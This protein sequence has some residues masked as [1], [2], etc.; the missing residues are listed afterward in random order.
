MSIPKLLAI[1]GVI[2]VFSLCLAVAGELRESDDLSE[3]LERDGLVKATQDQIRAMHDQMRRIRDE[4]RATTAVAA[5]V[6]SIVAWHKNAVEQ[7]IGGDE[8]ERSKGGG[9]VLEHSKS[10]AAR[11]NRP[12]GIAGIGMWAECNG[13]ELK[14]KNHEWL[15]D[16][17]QMP[18]LNRPAEPGLR[19]SFLR[20]HTSSGHLEK[21]DLKAHA[22][23]RTFSTSHG[24]SGSLPFFGGNA[25]PIRESLTEPAGGKETRPRNMSVV[26]IMRIK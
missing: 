16:D 9:V 1:S 6:G 5:P 24:G 4:L 10:T 22:H 12:F 25:G 7:L 17:I 11:A 26:W 14:R 8:N 2:C 18:D 21:G 23:M 15:P 13:Q 3:T 19:G 20:G